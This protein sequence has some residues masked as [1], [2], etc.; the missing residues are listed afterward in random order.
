MTKIQFDGL[1]YETGSV[2]NILALQ[3]IQMPHTKS[4]PSEALLLGLSGGITF[5]YFSFAYKG[6]DPHVALLT[7]NTFDPL[8]KLLDRLSIVRTV[9]QTT[10]A[11]KAEKNLFDALDNGQPVLVWAD[12]ISLPYNTYDGMLGDEMYMMMPVVVFGHDAKKGTVDIADQSR[13]PMKIDASILTRA[14]ARVK[15]EKFRQMTLTLPSFD[16]LAQGVASALRASIQSFYTSPVKGYATNFGFAAYQRWADALIN[17]KDKQSWNKIF[18]AGRPMFAG[19]ASAFERIELFGTGG[20]SSR[21]LFGDFLDEAS[22]LL[23]KP[24]LRESASQIRALAPLWT[25]LGKALLPDELPL[26]KETRQLMLKKRDLFWE[27]GDGATNEIKKIHARLKAIRKIMEKDFPLSDV[28][29]LALKQNLREHILRI[30]DA[31][32]EA[33]TKLEKAFLL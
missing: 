29:A 28:E 14:R 25:A 13:K 2:H 24:A 19:L 10:D 3:G 20:A 17:D 4:A 31:E 7:R 6:L 15:K 11:S 9:K 30:H 18:P 22:L 16:K 26:F 32:K 8:E 27:K 33:I 1:H 23:G 5:G 21:P 12:Q